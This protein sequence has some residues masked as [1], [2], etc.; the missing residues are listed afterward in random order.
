M[1]K[2]VRQDWYGNG[3]KKMESSEIRPVKPRL[4][5]DIVSRDICLER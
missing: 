5:S 3:S 2:I 4:K 1:D